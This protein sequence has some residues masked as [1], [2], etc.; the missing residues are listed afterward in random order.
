MGGQRGGGGTPGAGD[1]RPAQRDS[2]GRPG[3]LRLRCGHRLLQPG[4]DVAD[5]EAPVADRPPADHHRHRLRPQRDHQ[6]RRRGRRP[7]GGRRPVGGRLLRSA[8]E[9]PLGAGRLVRGNIRRSSQP[10]QQLGR[11]LLHHQAEPGRPGL[12]SGG[13]LPG[14]RLAFIGGRRLDQLRHHGLRSQ[15]P[16]PRELHR[17]GT[18]SAR[19][20]RSGSAVGASRRHRRDQRATASHPGSDPGAHRRGACSRVGEDRRDLGAPPARPRGRGGDEQRRRLRLQLQRRRADRAERPL[21]NRHHLPLRDRLRV[22]RRL[23]REATRR[24]SSGPWGSRMATWRPTSRFPRW[25]GPA[26][27]TSSRTPWR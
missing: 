4:R 12:E 25:C 1:R 2:A 13:E 14:E 3:G 9:R 16:A 19:A 24:R 18:R 26:S 27:I 23:Q 8:L 21:A 7:A 17:P 20:S 6:L 10:G 11:P 5:G 22:G 15:A